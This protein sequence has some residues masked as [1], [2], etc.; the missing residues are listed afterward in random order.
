MRAAGVFLVAGAMAALP[1][2]AQLRGVFAHPHANFAQ[3]SLSARSGFGNI[4]FPG[5]GGPPITHVPSFADRLG[6]TVSGSRAHLLRRGVFARRPR[7]IVYP[8]PVFYG[9]YWGGYA[10]PPQQIYVNIQQSSPPQP[11]VIIN[12]YY[13]APNA[14]PVVREYSGKNLPEPSGGL[15][16]FH[17]PVPDRTVTSPVVHNA[18][19]RVEKEDAEPTLYLIAFR[20]GT[21]YPAIGYWLEDGTLHYITP[22]GD[23]NQASLDLIDLKLTRRLNS[24]RG[25][26]F[27]LQPE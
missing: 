20:D 17:A 25:L 15:Q 18:D 10:S 16:T 22:K 19:S 13:T 14:Q 27:E 1:L 4:L 6:A 26:S 9:G 24:E 7:A 23:H 2:G 5:T 8:V 12:Q 3:R 21:I 11:P